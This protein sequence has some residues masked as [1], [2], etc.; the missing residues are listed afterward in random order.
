MLRGPANRIHTARP[1]GARHAPASWF[2]NVVDE[3]LAPSARRTVRSSAVWI[4]FTLPRI[5]R[6]LASPPAMPKIRIRT[7]TA[8]IDGI[9]RYIDGQSD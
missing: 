8:A 1:K 2:P 3:P 4:R 5:A 6:T 9:T 7:R